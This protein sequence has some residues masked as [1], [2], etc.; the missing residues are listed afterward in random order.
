M[1]HTV[2]ILIRPPFEGGESCYPPVGYRQYSEK[3]FEATQLTQFET[4]YYLYTIAAV[5][6]YYTNLVQVLEYFLFEMNL[7][8]M[9]FYE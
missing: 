9:I 4:G 3:T 2:K 1:A 6:I 5:I 8:S 7:D